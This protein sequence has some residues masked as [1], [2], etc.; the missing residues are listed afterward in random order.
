MKQLR[1]IDVSEDISDV[2]ARET[3]VPLLVGQQPHDR[4]VQQS[5]ELLGALE[6][7]RQEV[8]GRQ[9]LAICNEESDA[10]MPFVLSEV[11][12]C[13]GD[14]NATVD[15]L[16]AFGTLMKEFVASTLTKGLAEE[17]FEALIEERMEA[18]TSRLEAM[19]N[20]L[21]D[22]LELMIDRHFRDTSASLEKRCASLIDQRLESG[23]RFS[24]EWQATLD[25]MKILQGRIVAVEAQVAEQLDVSWGNE[26]STT[27]STDIIFA[28]DSEADMQ[29]RE[30]SRSQAVDIGIYLKSMSAVNAQ[31]AATLS[32][33]ALG[34]EPQHGQS[35]SFSSSVTLTPTI[36]N[37]ACGEEFAVAPSDKAAELVPSRRFVRL[38]PPCVARG[39]KENGDNHSGSHTATV[40]GSTLEVALG[41]RKQS[42][43][44]S[45]RFRA[46]EVSAY[47]PPPACE[48]PRL[49][50]GSS[51]LVG[52]PLAM[53]EVVTSVLGAH[54]EQLDHG[55]VRAAA[56]DRILA[57]TSE[58][59]ARDA[60]PSSA[61][62]LAKA[63]AAAQGVPVMKEVIAWWNLSARGEQ[64]PPSFKAAQPEPSKPLALSALGARAPGGRMASCVASGEMLG[65]YHLGAVLSPL[66]G[67]LRGPASAPSVVPPPG[68]LS[69]TVGGSLRGPASAPS[70]PAVRL[71]AADDEVRGGCSSS[72]PFMATLE[73]RPAPLSPLIGPV[74]PRG[75]VSAALRSSRAAAQSSHHGSPQAPEC[76]GAAVRR[77]LSPS[78]VYQQ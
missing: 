74:S 67:S 36:G 63:I 73:P 71:R 59:A 20:E 39:D 3:E 38:N 47:P 9:H 45:T 33:C 42:D 51:E 78:L 11:S 26:R 56:V 34:E 44:A 4:F 12:Q 53:H 72:S 50:A 61:E 76:L 58:V 60:E 62:S 29:H 54:R 16:A 28:P 68:P 52:E 65:Q 31:T 48:Q 70:P 66:G 21:S 55:R 13:R 22:A 18:L 10:M 35:F 43:L 19:M 17:Q 69:P 77:A 25:E 41:M 30:R 6:Q 57:Q 15:G 5:E 7:L 40:E 27:A 1:F 49:F 24:S 64:H 8:G 32:A 23:C 37:R 14:L 46:V 2:A 75:G